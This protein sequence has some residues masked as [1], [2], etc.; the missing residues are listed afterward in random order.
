MPCQDQVGGR[1]ARIV[2][3]AYTMY[4]HPPGCSPGVINT[5]IHPTSA[6]TAGKGKSHNKKARTLRQVLHR[7]TPWQTFL[8]SKDLAQAKMLDCLTSTTSSDVDVQSAKPERNLAK[9]SGAGAQSAA[10]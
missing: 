10:A 5:P 3:N 2:P 6:N 7:K 4:F 1:P 9:R 8:D